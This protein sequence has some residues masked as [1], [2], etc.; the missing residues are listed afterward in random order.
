MENPR[1]G[2]ELGVVGVAARQHL[3]A[4]G[5]EAGIAGDEGVDGSARRRAGAYGRQRDG[6]LRSRALRRFP[7]LGDGLSR[8]LFLDTL[9]YR[10]RALFLD[11]LF[12]LRRALFYLL[13]TLFYL[14]RA[15]FP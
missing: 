2:G 15:L 5:H 11:T 9:L 8:A 3:V 12:Y 1:R 13:D 7:R 6:R 10:R 4:F 14:R